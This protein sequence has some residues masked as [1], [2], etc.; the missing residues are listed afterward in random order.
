MNQ[1]ITGNSGQNKLV[2]LNDRYKQVCLDRINSE[3]NDFLNDYTP[4]MALSSGREKLPNSLLRKSK[5]IIKER[6][7]L[8]DLKR[9][10][11]PPAN[12]IR[13]GLN[14]VEFGIEESDENTYFQAL[15]TFRDSNSFVVD[16]F[17]SVVTSIV[18]MK[19]IKKFVRKEGVGNSNHESIGAIYLSIP[20]VE[21]STLQLAI[22]IAHEVGHQALMIFQTSDSIIVPEQLSRNVY[23][24]VRKVDRPAIQSFHALVALVYM[25]DFL[26]GINLQNKS[27]LEIDY[28]K[29]E[30]I[31]YECKL[32]ANVWDFKKISFTEIGSKIYSDIFYYV[33]SY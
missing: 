25:R 2:C 27:K 6:E 13:N 10:Y 23:S 17:N 16:V 4:W 21:C 26:K 33:E 14:T 5:L 31:D 8:E 15:A 12:N 19:T 7:K 32:K 1:W 18:P 22:N 24:C 3:R 28:I 9:F 20:E 30:L 11:I 29:T